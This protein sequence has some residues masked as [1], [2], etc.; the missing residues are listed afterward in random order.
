MSIAVLEPTTSPTL[1]SAV[2]APEMV[3]FVQITKAGKNT[4]FEL[5]NGCPEAQAYNGH[6]EGKP[7]FFIKV[8]EAQEFVSKETYAEAERT[9]IQPDM[10]ID[11]AFGMEIV[12]QIRQQNE[13][14]ITG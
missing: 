3:D 5:W 9:Y 7:G 2:P 4:I 6:H 13:A 8:I 12:E 1:T 11:E 10:V 14:F